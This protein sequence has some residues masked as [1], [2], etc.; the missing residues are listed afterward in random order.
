MVIPTSMEIGALRREYFRVQDAS[1]LSIGNPK[2]TDSILVQA[3]GRRHIED[4]VL[5]KAIYSIQNNLRMSGAE[6]DDSAMFEELD[7]MFPRGFH[8][9]D[10]N[11][12]LA[13]MMLFALHE[14]GHVPMFL[15]WEVTFAL[16]NLYPAVYNDIRDLI[17]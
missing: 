8:P 14:R 12:K 2:A 3:F 13:E 6:A 16:R 17:V 11:G 10:S 7:A 4:E 5:V 9:G 1:K 15:Q